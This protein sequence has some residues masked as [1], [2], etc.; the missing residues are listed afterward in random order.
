MMCSARSPGNFL[1]WI[2]TASVVALVISVPSTTRASEP[3]G[4]VSDQILLDIT[5]VPVGMGAL[6][7]PTLTSSSKEAPV[8][9][10]RGDDR[11][12]ISET[13]TRIILPPGEYRVVTGQGPMELRPSTTVRVSDS[14]TAAVEPFFGAIRIQSI[15]SNSGRPISTS[16]A[17]DVE[18]REV[19]QGSTDAEGDLDASE[20]IFVR[21]GV[22]KL[23]LP[24]TKTEL[25]LRVA[26]GEL[27]D[28][29]VVMEDRR[30]LRGEYA[31]SPLEYTESWWRLRWTVGADL[32]LNYSRNRLSSFNGE[33]L[34]LG[35]F[36]DAEF[37]IDH[38]NHL[39]VVNF[40]IDESWLGL[41]GQHGASV[42]VRKLVDEAKASLMY[43]YRIGRIFGPYARVSAQTSL[44][45]TRFYAEQETT[46]ERG[47]QTA[48]LGAGGELALMEGFSPLYLQQGG[49]LS[50]TVVDNEILNIGARGGVA[51]R[52]HRFGGG[53]FID[54][55][56][57]DGR[58]RLEGLRDRNY[59][60]LEGHA[61][62]GL[63]LASSFRINAGLDL[64][65]PNVQIIDDAAFEPIYGFT[66]LA[67]VSVNRLLSV[68]YR[69][70]LSRP[71]LQA[72][73]EDFH[74]V[75]LRIQHALF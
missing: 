50:L 33:Y 43:N 58:L 44:F 7:V 49:G 54:E 61:G 56:S 1:S 5:P 23:R 60:G 36:S 53:D 16:W 42:P 30:F 31:T 28:Y 66:G 27:V 25:E 70:M 52:Q 15:D 40:T 21:P 41:S 22:V 46:I 37:G 9:V 3:G 75:S 26:A 67:E 68:V 6:F 35:V 20:T 34:Q 63:R 10:F 72:P 19:A 32:A 48:T 59:L 74:G 39:A 55:A 24:N 2:V 8:L 62:I 12:A 69:T 29:R 47:E 71:N 73:R 4:D 11:A 51:L 45:E 57:A 64:F 65:V 18:D 38:Q 13:G 17:L 14:G